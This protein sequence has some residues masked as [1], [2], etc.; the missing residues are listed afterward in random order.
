MH[1]FIEIDGLPTFVIS[2]NTLFDA[3]HFLNLQ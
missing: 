2:T 1:D 3:G